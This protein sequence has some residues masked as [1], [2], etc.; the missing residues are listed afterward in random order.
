MLRGYIV[1]TICPGFIKTPMVTDKDIPKG[2]LR[3]IVRIHRFIINIS[4]CV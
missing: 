2:T 4:S 1:T 3:T